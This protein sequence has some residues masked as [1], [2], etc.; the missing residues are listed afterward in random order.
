MKIPIH[1][2]QDAWG[3][4]SYTFELNNV[5]FTEN[6]FPTRQRAL[7]GAKKYIRALLKSWLTP[8]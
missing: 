4:W 2:N 5:E 8:R 7:F 3:E 1:L 6:G